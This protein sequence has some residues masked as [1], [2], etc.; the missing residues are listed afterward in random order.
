MVYGQNLKRYWSYMGRLLM[1]FKKIA[2]IFIL[3]FALL[4][5]YLVIGIFVRQDIQYNSSQPTT[6]NVLTN[7]EELDINRPAFA[8]LNTEGK[9]IFP[10]QSSAH[11]QLDK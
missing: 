8:G 9:E 6:N 4:N 5:I 10:I 3:A 1:D 2:R 7:M 11:Q